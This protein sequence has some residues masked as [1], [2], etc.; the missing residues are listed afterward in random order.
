MLGKLI[1]INNAKKLLKMDDKIVYL[2]DMIEYHTTKG[3]L[4]NESHFSYYNLI[5]LVINKN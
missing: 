1:R 4:T 3:N 2:Q 5:N